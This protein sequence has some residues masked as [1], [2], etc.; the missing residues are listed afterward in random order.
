MNRNSDNPLHFDILDS[1]PRVL[2]LSDDEGVLASFT[3][4]YRGQFEILTTDCPFDAYNFIE[5]NSIQIV[6]ADHQMPTVSGVDFLEIIARDYPDVQR[7]LVTDHCDMQIMLEA[8]NKGKVGGV[9]SK[10]FKPL[11]IS[12]VVCDAWNRFKELVE[13]EVL[14]KQLQRQNQQFE[15]LLRQRMLS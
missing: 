2:L 15:F 4:N 10:P 7:V 9:L 3:A 14:M 12:N 1:K 11:E 8:I 6:L 13:K 5:D